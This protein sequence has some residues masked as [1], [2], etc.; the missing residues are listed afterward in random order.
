MAEKITSWRAKDGRM[1][2]NQQDAENHE[3]A[4]DP[5]CK[6]YVIAGRPDTTEGRYGPRVLGYIAVI[7]N[8]NHDMFAEHYMYKTFG[9]KVVFCMGYQ[10]SNAIMSNWEFKRSNATE[11]LKLL[12]T[13]TDK[14]LR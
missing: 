9:N 11:N 7:A 1:F 5:R 6:T 13:I 4:T 3:V 14:A 12:D 8:G 10:G 2:D